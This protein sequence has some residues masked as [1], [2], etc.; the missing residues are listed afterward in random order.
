MPEPARDLADLLEQAYSRTSRG[1]PLPGL[2]QTQA[3]VVKLPDLGDAMTRSCGPVSTQ[4]DA[5]KVQLVAVPSP[6]QES[7]RN[8]P[9]A[10]PGL[11]PSL[12]LLVIKDRSRPHVA[13]RNRR[14]AT[15]TP[16]VERRQHYSQ[17][18]ARASCD[19]KD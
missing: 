8:I 15:K 17:Y 13:A 1:L 3:P 5:A 16:A 18:C 12:V 2:N 9:A 6:D 10:I 7:Q 14:V 19:P 4:L 11:Y